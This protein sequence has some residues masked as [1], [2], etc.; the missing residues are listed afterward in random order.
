[1]NTEIGFTQRIDVAFEKLAILLYSGHDGQ[2]ML[3]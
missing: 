3:V 2:P 1:M